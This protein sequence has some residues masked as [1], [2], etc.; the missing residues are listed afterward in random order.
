MK[1]SKIGVANGRRG[2]ISGVNTNASSFRLSIFGK[3][4]ILLL[5][6]ALIPLIIASILN[7]RRGVKTVEETALGNQQLVAK[8]TA[9]R[10]DQLITDI[11]R[12][13]TLIATEDAVRDFCL[14]DPARREVSSAAVTA[15]LKEVTDS[16]PD[17]AT[18]FIAGTDG[19]GIAST[20][21]QNVGQDL[22]FREYMQN[23]L[24]G[25]RFVSELVVGKTTREPGIYF[26]CPI[27]DAKGVVGALVIK[28]KG[29]T[30]YHICNA[31]NASI[32]SG[33]AT[34][35]DQYGIVISHPIQSRLYHSIGTLSDDVLKKIDPQV[36]YSIDKIESL[37]NETLMDSI[38]RASK[39]GNVAFNSPEGQ[40]MV[41]GF[42][43]MNTKKWVVGV[44]QPRSNFDLPMRE[45]ERQQYL[46]VL[47]VAILATIVALYASRRL[48]RPIRSLSE[49][50]QKVAQGDFS[51]RAQVSTRDELGDLSKTFNAMIPQ[52]KERQEM[53]HAMRLAMEIQKHLLPGSGPS[54]DGLDVCG[55]NIPADQT[56]GDYYDFLDL[57]TWHEGTLAVAIGDVTGHG[58]SAALLMATGRA[59]LRSRATPPGSLADLIRDVNSRLC[60]DAPEG[61]F[62]TLN[63]LLLDRRRREL[64]MVSAGH[65]AIIMYD[66]KTDAF[67]DLE[68]ADVPLGVDRDWNFSELV[69]DDIPE[70]AILLGGT[71]GVWEARNETEEFFGKERLQELIRAHRSG[72]AKEICAAVTNDLIRFRGERRQLDDVTV[73]V[74]R[75]TSYWKNRSDAPMLEVAKA[76]SA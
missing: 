6:A 72:T 3:L 36:S 14:A 2:I 7:V 74:I 12:L 60:D 48:V 24:A 45:L 40:P 56:G 41:A 37:G 73:V 71:D 68:G 75:V 20:N 16:N 64:R 47:A 49:A 55:V 26:S 33:F 69:Y 21:P 54:I 29:E 28:L 63:Y 22:K 57:S 19:V 17:L 65:D 35:V 13:S 5:V 25:E 51:A 62:M 30:I 67:R 11:S 38:M 50:A 76:G 32:G 1:L 59:L 39:S 8:V 42:A 31:V 18:C 4:V 61:R 10:L 34:I 27:R 53:E 44:V 46:I 70:G 66:P 15:R 9:T 23:A 52:L 43:P 58:I